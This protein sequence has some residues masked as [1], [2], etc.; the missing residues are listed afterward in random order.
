MDD[1]LPSSKAAKRTCAAAAEQENT[2][3]GIMSKTEKK[4]T[5]AASPPKKKSKPLENSSVSPL[6]DTPDCRN[7]SDPVT[8]LE[9][10]IGH[11]GQREGV[12]GWRLESPYIFGFSPRATSPPVYTMEDHMTNKY[13]NDSPA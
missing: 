5:A 12:P 1:S 11:G 8:R 10:R 2:I 13:L 4:T 3:V 7:P 6:V 9:A